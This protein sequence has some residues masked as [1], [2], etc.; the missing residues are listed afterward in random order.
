MRGRS[1][2]ARRSATRCRPRAAETASTCRSTRSSSCSSRGLRLHHLHHRR[3]R[4]LRRL[5]LHHHHRRP[6]TAAS[7]STAATTAAT[8]TT[9]ASGALPR[10]EGARAASGRRE[11][12]D[13]A[14]ALLRRQHP[15][16]SRAPLAAR[17]CGQPVTEARHDQ[18]PE[19]PGQAGDRPT[20]AE[21]QTTDRAGRL[22]PPRSVSG[23]LSTAN[24]SVTSS[25][26]V[27]KRKSAAGRPPAAR[28]A[29][30][31]WPRGAAP[32]QHALEV[33][34]GHV[35]PKRRD[36]DLS[37]LERERL[38]RER[39]ADVR[40][41]ELRAEPLPSRQDDL[42]VVERHLRQV[43]D[44]VPAVSAGTSG[45]TSSGTR[46]RY[47]V[48]SCHSRGWRAGSLS[49]SSCSRWESSCTSTFAARC[50]RS[51]S[52]RSRP[53]QDSR[54]GVTRRRR[55]LFR[56]LP[57]QGLECARA[58]LEHDRERHMGG[59]FSPVRRKLV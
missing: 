10:P 8:P 38:R 29:A 18:A 21:K 58:H 32:H 53:A 31:R 26:G 11:D 15:A 6:T 39:E 37:K 35:V 28:R 51:D 45:S 5:R 43:V 57:E 55:R 23:G 7:T 34:R 14:G 4:R 52:S 22:H 1:P 40:V 48:A 13:P 19:L 16:R 2:A 54:P 9:A 44:R 17:P 42:A 33:R 46:P 20:L 49:V 30:S 59:G 56:A 36:V 50:L 27:R 47:A 24:W 12:E 25:A 3:L 41:R